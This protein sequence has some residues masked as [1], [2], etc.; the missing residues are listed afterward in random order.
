[1]ILDLPRM[2]ATE[3]PYWT[4]LEKT[5]DLLE[6]D[7]NRKLTIR[8]T[9]RF[10]ALYERAADALARVGDFA[11]EGDL[12]RYL[13]WL[14]SRA[15][16]EIHET[17][18]HQRV[19]PWR[20]FFVD[21]PS[22]FRRQIRAFQFAVALS[23]AGAAFG[24]FAIQHDP[25]AKNVL[26]PFEG[27]RM[28]PAQR[29]ARER[30]SQG[31]QLA[32][33]KD[34]FSAQLITHNTQVAFMTL[35]LGITFGL[36]TVIVLFYNGVILGAV[37]LDYILGGQTAFLLGWLLPHGVIEIPAILIGGQAGL[38][39]AHA[40]IGWGDRLSRGE[41]LRRVSGD[42]AMLAC[43][44]AVLLVW[45]GLVEAFISQYHEPVLPYAIK[46]GFG[47]VEALVLTIFLSRAGQARTGAR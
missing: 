42:V 10:H 16:A 20:W 12:Q 8:E 17:R 3:Q 13:A 19:R 32:G 27:L 7:P 22:A 21:F 40:M 14:V 11:A 37:A 4:A 29:V 31:R 44:V 43:G 25:E 6:R 26:M 24:G 41:R 36:G 45:A 47:L 30:E 1:V 39:I 46:I 15:Y 33:N 18:E 35:A 9:E 23:I 28:T 34:R 2:I 5:L 38:V